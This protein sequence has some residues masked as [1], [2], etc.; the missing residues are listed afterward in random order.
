M[1]QSQQV[2]KSLINNFLNWCVLKTLRVETFNLY[3]ALQK[4]L[5]FF[6]PP[7]Q[8]I[9]LRQEI[10]IRGKCQKVD[11]NPILEFSVDQ[12]FG[13]FCVSF[14]FVFKKRKV[15]QKRFLMEW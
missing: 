15:G 14:S 1:L 10:I 11:L 8:A 2:F 4:A 13:V 9:F 12:S 6:L 7:T 5:F 3:W